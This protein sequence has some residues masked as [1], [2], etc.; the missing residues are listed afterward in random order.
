MASAARCPHGSRSSATQNPVDFEGTY[1]LPARRSSSRFLMKI[2]ILSDQKPKRCRF[3]GGI[4]Q[5]PARAFLE[6]AAIAPIPAGLLAAARAGSPRH[7]HRAGAFTA[8]FWP[9]ARRTR[10]WPTLSLKA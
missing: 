2:R 6:D 3:S 1:P 10:E 4:T 5:A 7:P 8:T 9:I